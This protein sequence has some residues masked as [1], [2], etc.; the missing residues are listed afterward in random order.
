M[1]D[2]CRFD[3][4]LLTTADVGHRCERT[5]TGGDDKRAG[6]RQRRN[7]YKN[8]INADH[9]TVVGGAFVVV[10]VEPSVVI[11][12]SAGPAAVRRSRGMRTSIVTIS[13]MTPA[14][15]KIQPTT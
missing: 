14:A 12:S 4:L 7:E 8:D 2:P 11:R 10:S 13:P 15:I 5:A 9:A 6:E 1:T 3:R